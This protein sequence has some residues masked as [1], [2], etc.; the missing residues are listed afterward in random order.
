MLFN[1]F[2]GVFSFC[3]FQELIDIILRQSPSFSLL[4]LS[5]F[6]EKLFVGVIGHDSGIFPSDLSLFIQVLPLFDGFLYGFKT[7]VVSQN[8]PE[9]ESC[10]TFFLNSSNEL[11]WD[12]HVF[13][14]FLNDSPCI[15]DS[16][17]FELFFAFCVASG[18]QSNPHLLMKMQ[19][20]KLV[21]KLA[22]IVH[23][24]LD[25]A[26]EENLVLGEVRYIL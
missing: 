19:K 1:L 8:I 26:H 22:L 23:V 15:L 16:L 4:F 17:V 6:F 12:C 7:E 13:H 2:D 11:F 25:L 9:L 10:D 24:M 21:I 3:F 5:L 20:L 14:E 18:H